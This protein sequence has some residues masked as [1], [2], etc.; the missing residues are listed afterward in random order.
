MGRPV[1][2]FVLNFN[3][4]FVVMHVQSKCFNKWTILK[5]GVMLSH[6]EFKASEWWLENFK[7]RHN[8][9]QK[10]NF[11]E[12]GLF[13]VDIVEEWINHTLPIFLHDYS[14]DNIINADETALCFNL[15][16]CT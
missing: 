13:Y 7:K 5:F 2:F 10:S 12:A 16:D 15:V 3:T 6:P 14:I 4:D 8:I 11:G 9:V 1:A